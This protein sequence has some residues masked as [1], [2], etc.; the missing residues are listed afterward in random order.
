MNNLNNE[1]VVYFYTEVH[2]NTTIANNLST[3]LNRF[4]NLFSIFLIIFSNS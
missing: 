4:A 2:L 1:N 3:D